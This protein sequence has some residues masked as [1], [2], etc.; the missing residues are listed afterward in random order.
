MHLSALTED[1]VRIKN[2]QDDS[3]KSTLMSS[4]SRRTNFAASF[5]QSLA[6]LQKMRNCQERQVLKEL[7]ALLSTLWPMI[8]FSAGTLVKP[9]CPVSCWY[10]AQDLKHW[11]SKSMSLWLG[12]DLGTCC[13]S[14]SLRTLKR[15]VQDGEIANAFR[16]PM[17]KGSLVAL[18]ARQV[19]I[20][21]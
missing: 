21:C 5:Q 4:I 8:G 18:R 13:C 7:G 1:F 6:S 20:P 19:K 9:P 12:L 16:W 2:L 3:I 11:V 10:A 14:C 17:K 15:G